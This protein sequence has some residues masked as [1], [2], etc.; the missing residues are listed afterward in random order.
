MNSTLKFN[1]TKPQPFRDMGGDHLALYAGKCKRCSRSVYREQDV[2][3]G[4]PTGQPYEAD[5]RGAITPTHAC[6]SLNAEEFGVQGT[7]P[8][9][10]FCWDCLWEGGSERYQGCLDIAMR[11]W[12]AR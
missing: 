3:D 2:K 1:T 5:P 10:L 12:G 6:A 4:T 8:V 9:A 7:A 11:M